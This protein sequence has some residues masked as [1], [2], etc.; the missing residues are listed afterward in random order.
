[1]F[2]ESC[3]ET[4][5][6]RLAN[7]VK[8]F[9]S[10]CELNVDESHALSAQSKASSELTPLQKL[11]ISHLLRNNMKSI[12]ESTSWG[13]DETQKQKEL[14]APMSRYILLVNPQ[15]ANEVKAFTMF[16]FEWDDE[17]EPEH[18]VLF[19]YEVQV[20]STFS[21]KGLGKLLMFM[22]LKIAKHCHMWKTMLTC[23]KCNLNAMAFYSRIGFSM[24]SNSPSKYGHNDEPYEILSSSSCSK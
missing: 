7:T 11:S 5:V 19:C 2:D 4:E 24:D 3:D 14:F 8:D 9:I 13:W 6:I 16:R 12:Y 23:F 20:D 18:P 1:M 22:L 17:E 10:E 21:R 15:N